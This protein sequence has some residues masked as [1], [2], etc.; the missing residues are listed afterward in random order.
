MVSESVAA[1][2]PLVP[3]TVKLKGLG[4]LALRPVTVTVLV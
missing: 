1:C 4:V 3:I 2:E